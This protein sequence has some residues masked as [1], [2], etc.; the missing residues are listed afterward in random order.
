MNKT[1]F[2]LLLLTMLTLSACSSNSN[3]PATNQAASQEQTNDVTMP[4]QAN[5]DQSAN[6]D[7]VVPPVDQQ[8]EEGTASSTETL[9]NTTSTDALTTPPAE[10]V[11]ASASTTEPISAETND[12]MPQ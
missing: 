12:A 6:S 9:E 8:T 7:A 3:S 11:P 2:A 5:T 1:V 10:E 4:D